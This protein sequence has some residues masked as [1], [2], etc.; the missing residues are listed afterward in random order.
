MRR[1]PLQAKAVSSSYG[2]SR[3]C[4]ASPVRLRLPAGLSACDAYLPCAKSAAAALRQALSAGD[5]PPLCSKPLSMLHNVYLLQHAA[6]D[7]A[8]G[9]DMAVL[10][11]WEPLHPRFKGHVAHHPDH[12]NVAHVGL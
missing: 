3:P 10:I 1:S 2:F 12:R 4:R 8:V 6:V 11:A 9:D 7:V 5:A